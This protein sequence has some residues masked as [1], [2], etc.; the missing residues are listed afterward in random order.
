MV[1]ICSA[2]RSL[3]L[4]SAW[5]AGAAAAP[6]LTAVCGERVGPCITVRRTKYP[7]PR[8][9]AALHLLGG[10]GFQ[11]RQRNSFLAPLPSWRP[12][13]ITGPGP[14][15]GPGHT[16]GG[17]VASSC[18]RHCLP[19][20]APKCPGGQF[21]LG[22]CALHPLS[23]EAL[24]DTPPPRSFPP[25]ACAPG[26]SSRPSL[27]WASLIRLSFR[28]YLL[29]A[30]GCSELRPLLIVVVLAALRCT[31][32]PRRFVFLCSPRPSG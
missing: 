4:P 6:E 17:G 13:P 27:H 18:F 2:L 5:R 22:P 10:G 30:I 31:A 26:P 3:A 1:L 24:K 28:S 16:W 32:S 7:K 8:L 9:R 12:L 14:S 29:L 25:Q 21:C 19:H 23:L 15:P 11:E 20:W